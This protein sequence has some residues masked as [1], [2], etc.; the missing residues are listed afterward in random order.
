MNAPEFKDTVCRICLDENVV[1]DWCNTLVEHCNITY[2]DCYYKYT[3]L[4]CEESDP[5]SSMLCQ[6]CSNGLEDVHT[7][8]L[9]ALD[10][11]NFL[12]DVN[13]VKCEMYIYSEDDTSNIEDDRNI[14]DDTIIEEV[15]IIEDDL[16]IE[17][18][19]NYTSTE[20]ETV[21]VEKTDTE[22]MEYFENENSDEESFKNTSEKPNKGISK[23][24]TATRTGLRN[25]KY[26]NIERNEKSDIDRALKTDNSERGVTKSIN[27]SSKSSKRKYT[28]KPVE[29]VAD[30]ADDNNDK[31]LK[32]T[33]RNSRHRK[34]TQ[35]EE[36]EDES[37]DVKIEDCDTQTESGVK[38]K[39]K[40]DTPSMCSIC[41]KILHNKYSL[42]KHERTHSK[43]RER[44][45]TCPICGIKFFEKHYIKAHMHI[46]SENRIKKHKCEFC[47]KAFYE[48][49]G[50][51]VHRRI[52]LGQMKKCT[53]CAKEFFRQVD[54]DIHMNSHSA[55][56]LNVNAKKRSK[57]WV[58]CKYCDKNI[59][60]T[61]F[62]SHTAA[63]LN[64]PLMKCSICD[65]EFFRRDC[66]TQ[67]VKSIHKKSNEEY[68][69]FI[70]TY[71]NNRLSHLYL[72]QTADILPNDE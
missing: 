11:Y 43:N 26:V 69:D 13:S 64:E 47:D 46:H 17:N 10:S 8:I 20:F 63:H 70:I 36:L 15:T 57:Y 3:Q 67:H 12:M 24:N 41:S 39:N 2:R 4:K 50:L 33:S 45:A 65:K 42:Q 38:K 72:E 30:Q 28:S 55:T 34:I 44:K 35:T 37:M 49:G 21:L 32:K 66:C 1:L 52:H 61:S 6:N 51:N 9:K 53:L 62:K 58:R 22:S 14:E 23:I 68:K 54:L 7:L 25:Q 31:Q 29:E 60:S 40:Y 59:L 48:K 56:S 19:L 71:N 27:G 16:T 18:D 5:F